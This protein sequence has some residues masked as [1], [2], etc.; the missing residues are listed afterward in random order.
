MRVRHFSSPAPRI[1]PFH[2]HGHHVPALALTEHL[3]AVLPALLAGLAAGVL[4]ICFLRAASLRWS[5]ALLALPLAPLAWVIG[6]Q[7][8]LALAL[9]SG[10]AAGIGAYWHLEDTY[11]G[12]EEA[13]RVR[14]AL[15]PVGFA[16]ARLAERHAGG[17]R[18]A[19]GGLALGVTPS[20]RICRVPFGSEQGVHAL[21]LGA[22]GSGKTVS[23]AA[24]A[25][26]YVRAGMG[27]IVLDP[28][29]DPYLRAVLRAAALESGV[30]L[31]EWSPTGPSIYNPFA[32]GGP[33]EV[34]D[35]ALAG[36][37]WSEPHYELATQRLLGMVTAT[38]R[39]AGQ[40]PPTLSG[41]V[42][43]MDPD[44]LD[45]LA[46]QVGGN[47]AATVSAYVDGL[48]AR[49]RADL[50]GGRDRLAVLAEGELGRWLDPAIGKGPQLDL[51]ESL[52]RGEVV[53]FHIDSDRYPAASRLLGAALVI[54]LVTLTADMQGGE[55]RGL[56]VVDE[57]A[58]LAADHV[59]RLFGRARSAGLSVLLG[60]Q[61][62]A[63]LRTARPDDQT[64]SLTEQVLTNVAYVVAH[65]EAD[66][67]SA[68]R[69]AR[70]IGTEPSWTTTTKV[71]GRREN[72]WSRAEGSR[73][74]D[75]Q[76]VIPPDH[77][78]RLSTGFA[79]VI[80][81]TAKRPGEVVRVARPEGP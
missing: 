44:R 25:Q 55:L 58:A 17:E 2:P 18:V 23:Q 41:L 45:A 20:G 1:Y 80:Q 54:D 60:T 26:A 34:T 39:S 70:V 4:A 77:F 12:G 57:F 64:D 40:W 53:Y 29:G 74:P 42:R 35:K 78:K 36:H 66:P 24:I 21:V 49:G 69:L 11:R 33:T 32:R 76:F 56:A 68:E 15:G 6:W 5:W 48:S 72:W 47:V 51:M 73:T 13:R 14:D 37:R 50:A 46:A 63:D 62:L 28:K 43:F 61:S 71:G 31:R 38:M 22:T 52:R 3:N 81:P 59:H 10:T 65:R 27:A 7:L 8:G 9:A 79:V 67:D 16:R 75:R 19:E 30:A